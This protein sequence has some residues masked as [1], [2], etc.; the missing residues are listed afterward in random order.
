MSSESSVV[1]L[2]AP[3]D[4]PRWIAVIET[5]ANHHSVW[6]FIKPIEQGETRSEL[7]K[8]SA[9]KPSTYSTDTNATIQ[10]LEPDQLKRYDMAY[11]IYKDEHKVW[12][13]RQTTIN[14]IDDYIM[15]TTGAYWSTIE[16][17]QGV[18]K[19]L[20]QL[21]D[22]VAP[23]SYAREQEVL[24][25]YES[26]RRSAKATKTEEWLRQWESVLSDL[27]ERKLP[28]AEGIRPTRAFLQAVEKIQPLFSQ[29][30]SNTIESEA[31]M[32]PEEDLTTRIPNGFK[33]AQIFRNQ[34]NLITDTTA[35]FS[36]ATATLQGK[37]ALKQDQQCFEGFGHH[38]LDRCLYLRKDLRPDGW[39]MRTGA[40]RRLLE[41]LKKSPDLQ[42]RHQEA[43]KEMEDFL[44]ESK[45]EDAP[46]L[47]AQSKSI[48]GQ[49]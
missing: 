31:V 11:R 30:W 43:I 35:A 18:P 14:D 16:R 6:N 7:V 44:N 22:H 40:V 15:R 26:I 42:E 33:I 27:K 17:I 13:K 36:T 48:V 39:T 21:K 37:E 45:K 8:P 20:Q 12:E 28:E 38:T 47:K 9:P 5:K 46:S 24:A 41:G 49:A 10:S 2:K 19:R 32:H 3:A 25:R 4:W 1:L 23:T 34:A 29:T